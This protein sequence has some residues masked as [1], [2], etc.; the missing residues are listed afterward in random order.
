[1]ETNYSFGVCEAYPGFSHLPQRLEL[2]KLSLNLAKDTGGCAEFYDVA[3]AYITFRSVED[4]SPELI[5]MR[6][7]TDLVKHDREHGT[8]YFETADRY[9]KNR[10]NAVRTAND[11]FI[12]RSTLLYRLERI[13]TQFGLDLDDKQLP[14]IHLLVSLRLAK[15]NAI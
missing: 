7:I 6:S 4:C 8:C 14:L 15:E 2:A 13:K 12:H 1:M 9:I 5:C 3:D 10:F 11:L